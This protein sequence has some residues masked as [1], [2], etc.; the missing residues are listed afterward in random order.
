MK[1]IRLL[2]VTILMTACSGN[3]NRGFIMTVKGPV[4]SDHTGMWLTHE[5]VL[6]DFI[7][8]DSINPDRYDRVEVINK[9]LPFLWKVKELGCNTFVECTPEYLGRDP[10]L[11]KTLS[12]SAGLNF[13]TNT[14]FYGAGNNKYV[15]SYAFSLSPEEIAA[16]WI[17]E[18]KNGIGDTGIKPGFIKTAV[19]RDSLSDFHRKLVKAA[20]LTHLATGLTIASHTGPA[21]PAFQELE[22]LKETGVDP[23]AFIWV[24]ANNE[25]DLSK[26]DEAARMGAWLSID[27]LNDENVINVIEILRFM[28]DQRVLD[29][30]LVSHD[31]GWFDPAKE[32]GG[33]FR[34]FNTLFEKL[35]PELRKEGFTEKE[36]K[37]IFEE[38]PQNAFAVRIRKL[39]EKR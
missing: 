13:M 5:H 21:L 9:V 16:I 18:W 27:N 7:G 8:A 10:I 32:N 38:N 26:L 24:H 31:A 35:I 34:G 11:L 37:L 14:G 3:A 36:I 33:N 4:S 39:K 20:A 6:V 2:V 19:D 29:K 30:V 22:V 12:D 1:T 17:R 25:K 15:P 28:R 23:S